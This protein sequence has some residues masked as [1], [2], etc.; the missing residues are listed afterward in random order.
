VLLGRAGALAELAGELAAGMG[1][2]PSVVLLHGMAG[3]GKT[4]T[5]A[6]AAHEF[7]ARW[8]DGRFFLSA[9]AEDAERAAVLR[10]VTAAP[11]CLLVLDDVTSAT[12]VRSMIPDNPGCSVLLT[13]RCRGARLPVTRRVELAPLTGETVIELFANTVGA[14]RVTR[15]P[16]AL[17]RLV[18]ATAGLPALVLSVAEALRGRPGSSLAEFAERLLRPNES[19][20][21]ELH[22]RALF[23]RCYQELDSRQA[24][25]LRA[26]ARQSAVLTGAAVAAATGLPPSQAESLV[27]DLVDRGLLDRDGPDGYRFPPLVRDYVRGRAREIEPLTELCARVAR[28]TRHLVLDGAHAATMVRP[29]HRPVL[30]GPR[31]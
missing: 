1:S 11:R 22:L 31:R 4:A 3:V 21:I 17:S 19:G 5:A 29:A 30:R 26:A 27:A 9:D 24:K 8:P 28:L 14:M 13:S 25:V 7:E 16:D 10:A 23:D 12:R 18:D 2:G 6:W 20:S 15:E